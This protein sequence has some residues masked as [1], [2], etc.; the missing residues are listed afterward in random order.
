[1][2]GKINGLTGS[3]VDFFVLVHFLYILQIS[4]AGLFFKHTKDTE[5]GFVGVRPS[6]FN[7]PSIQIFENLIDLLPSLSSFQETLR[8]DFLHY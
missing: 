3:H 2:V 4:T 5:G 6:L 8:T 7:E 1:M